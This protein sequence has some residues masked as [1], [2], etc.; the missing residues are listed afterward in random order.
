MSVWIVRLLTLIPEFEQL[1]ADVLGAS[2]P[3]PRRQ[4]AD[5]GR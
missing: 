5:Q 4:V 1:A 3:S 2:Q